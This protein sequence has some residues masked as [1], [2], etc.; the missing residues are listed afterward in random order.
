MSEIFCFCSEGCS[1]AAG[2]CVCGSKTAAGK[3]VS[4]MIFFVANLNASPPRVVPLLSCSLLP[5]HFSEEKV[6]VGK[7]AFTQTAD[8]CAG[9]SRN[10]RLKAFLVWMCFIFLVNLIFFRTACAC[11]LIRKRS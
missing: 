11:G 10:C 4:F 5:K 8:G 6:V 2:F 7:G 9:L 3:T 1:A